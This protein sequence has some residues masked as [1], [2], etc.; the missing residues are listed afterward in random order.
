MPTTY[1][2]DECHTTAA[3]LDG[4]LLV[5]VSFLFM[6]PNLPAPP[7]GRTLDATAPDL[8]FDKPECRA[9]WCAQAGI[10]APAPPPNA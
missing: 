1:E 4:W 3:S 2:C 10:A 6:N 5:S 7:G 8:L 9:A